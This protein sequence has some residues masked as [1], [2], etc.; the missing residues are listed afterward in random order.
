[1]KTG[2]LGLVVRALGAVGVAAGMTLAAER[3]Y[4]FKDPKNVNTIYFMLDSALEPIMGLASGIAGK[5]KFDPADPS[6]MSGQ[7][8]VDAK[9]LHTQNKSMT[10]VLHGDDWLDVKKY[11]AIEF[12]FKKIDGARKTADNTWEMT[13]QG[14][15]TCKGVAKPV[16]ANVQAVHHPGRLGERVQ[17]RKGDLLILR[18]TFTIKRAD[19][20][21]KADATG[22]PIVADDIEIRVSIVGISPDP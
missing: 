6:K 11:P 19:F 17:K 7:I 10:D 14:E 20:G 15:L 9:T 12:A 16:S 2:R 21:I 3:E 18:S 4:D 1:M 8:S 5:V 13:V 22:G